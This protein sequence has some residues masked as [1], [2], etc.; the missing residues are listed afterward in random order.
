MEVVQES[1]NN[2]NFT[3]L[4][5]LN[6]TYVQAILLIFFIFYAGLAAP[7][8]PKMFAQLFDFTIF[9]ILVLA[10]ILL[11]NNYNPTIALMVAIGFFITLQTLSRHKLFD[12]ASEVFKIR[13]LLGKNGG[14]GEGGEE[15]NGSLPP[16]PGPMDKSMNGNYGMNMETQVSGLA[17]R[18]PYY[19]GPQG[20]KHPVGFGGVVEG[21]DLN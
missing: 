14:E 7:K 12:M 17:G 6:N 2:I 4:Q 11:V 19:N 20:M 21:S 9:K 5:F 8:L 13:K 18:T 10:F 1:L 3:L 15:E 16:S